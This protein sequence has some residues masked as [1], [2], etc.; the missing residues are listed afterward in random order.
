ME[1]YRGIAAVAAA[2]VLCFFLLTFLEPRFVM[3]HLYQS[4]VYI[5]LLVM[6]YFRE[7]RWAYMI[8]VLTSGVW[9]TLVCLSPVM[10]NAIRGLREVRTSDAVTLSVS[11]L[12]ITTAMF[13]L[14]MMALCGRHWKKE[15]SGLGMG[16]KT[17]LV[18][19][20]IV[21]LYYGILVHW[22]WEMIPAS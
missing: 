2:Q 1:P 22:F 5:S 18:S 20:G 21:V 6:L 13:A 3:I 14:L 16:G 15:Y 7:D 11:A 8:G 19:L 12:A 4:I 10:R 17:F 9:L